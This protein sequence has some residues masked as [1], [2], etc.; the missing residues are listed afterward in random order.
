M[1]GRGSA[2]YNGNVVHIRLRPQRHKLRYRVFYML[3]A[4]DEIDGLA[5]RLR[6]FSHNRFNLLSFHDSDYGDGSATPIRQQVEILL[7]AAG[8][9]AEG[10][11]QLLT[12]PRVFGYSFNPISTFFCHDL[13]GS[14]T[15]ILYEVNNTFGQRH[16]YLAPVEPGSK[17]RLRQRCA[18]ALYVS[19]F[20]TTNMTYSFVVKP[21][22]D[23]VAI[24]IVGYEDKTPLIIA[25]LTAERR[26]MT[27]ASLIK[28]LLAYPMLTL[29]VT[30]GIYFEALI[31]WLKGVRLHD[32]PAP[33]DV[34]LTMAMQKSPASNHHREDSL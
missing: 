5:S 12:M 26:E 30:A 11:I 22:G 16:I 28:A 8:L 3:V 33:P 13:Y 1:Q 18:K 21:P 9:S 32:R 24:S 17:K 15:A 20:M 29:K 31:L 19:P 34:P 10:R 2:L 23:S 25:M 14:L 7:R 4:L 6:F 27:D